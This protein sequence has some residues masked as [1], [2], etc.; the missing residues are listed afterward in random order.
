M[1]S[2]C[3]RSRAWGSGPRSE[4]SRLQRHVLDSFVL[5]PQA[6]LICSLGQLWGVGG[7]FQA[8]AKDMAFVPS[9]LK[10]SKIDVLWFAIAC[11][12]GVWVMLQPSRGDDM[13]YAGAWRAKT[14]SSPASLHA[15]FSR[16][17]SGFCVDARAFSVKA[18]S[19][20]FCWRCNALSSRPLAPN[21]RTPHKPQ[22]TLAL[23]IPCAQ[24]PLKGGSQQHLFTWM[25]VKIRVPFWV[26]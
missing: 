1:I 24:V 9:G 2:T 7:G 3:S 4:A 15:A 17:C 5:W 13:I 12:W 23:S 6:H 19:L 11:S 8:E 26:P 25:V 18:R 16:G 22:D 21:A 10:T 14:K 20:L